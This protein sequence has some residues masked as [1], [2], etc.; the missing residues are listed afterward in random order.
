MDTDIGLEDEAAV[1]VVVVVDLEPLTSVVTMEVV[2]I[3]RLPTI[4]MEV[5]TRTVEEAAT[6]V[7][8][9]EAIINI[10]VA[11]ETTARPT[12]TGSKA[13]VK[14][15]NWN[16]FSLETFKDDC[17][18]EHGSPWTILSFSQKYEIILS[19]SI[20]LFFFINTKS[21]PTLKNLMTQKTTHYR[22]SWNPIFQP[23]MNM[24]ERT[25]TL[26]NTIYSL[27]M[28]RSGFPKLFLDKKQ[29]REMS[30]LSGVNLF[31]QELWI[32]PG[33]SHIVY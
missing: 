32:S 18:E 10:M 16:F 28:K 13:K 24:N 30:T 15:S 4:V 2:G 20:F 9:V 8:M 21:T 27:Y 5:V 23:F 3:V 6:V 7:V 11:A 29:E 22:T 12:T 25:P 19:S 14:E 1:D 17:Q 31:S 33:D 26:R